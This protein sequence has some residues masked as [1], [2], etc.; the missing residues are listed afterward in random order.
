MPE[1]YRAFG[2]FNSE[3][4]ELSVD[5]AMLIAQERNGTA[6]EGE[7]P[8]GIVGGMDLY[9]Q[10]NPYDTT[11]ISER[12]T[13]AVIPLWNGDGQPPPTPGQPDP[14]II[15]AG[16]DIS[17]GIFSLDGNTNGVSAQ[18]RFRMNFSEG[19][20]DEAS[21]SY[22]NFNAVEYAGWVNVDPNDGEY[23]MR[24]T[25]TGTPIPSNRYRLN[26]GTNNRTLGEAFPIAAGSNGVQG[27]YYSVYTFGDIAPSTRTAQILIEICKD[28]NGLPDENWAS[29]TVKLEAIFNG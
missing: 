21:A 5:R 14:S 26:D 13:D 18:I 2:R 11:I 24:V 17:G 23:W 28:F 4:V 25:E 19:E 27:P 15:W 16:A 12:G 3:K 6:V 7:P 22:P 10:L 8:N 20:P 1:N 9:T 29:R